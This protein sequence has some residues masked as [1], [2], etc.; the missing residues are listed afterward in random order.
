MGWLLLLL[1]WG[2][3]MQPPRKDL[4]E[5]MPDAAVAGWRN[6]RGK[7]ERSSRI[8]IRLRPRWGKGRN[9]TVLA[10]WGS[11]LSSRLQPPRCS[12]EMPAG[13]WVLTTEGSIWMHTFIFGPARLALILKIWLAVAGED[14]GGV[15]NFNFP[16]QMASL[17]KVLSL[18]HY[19]ILKM[20]N[21]PFRALMRKIDGL[22]SSQET[23]GLKIKSREHHRVHY[24]LRYCPFLD[25]GVSIFHKRMG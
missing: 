22:L 1:I 4:P 19:H 7:W 16:H 6:G 9:N 24:V 15:E 18:Q 8:Q 14:W 10:N 3:V 23:G 13:T 2:S 25:L 12:V 20:K 5:S 21:Q 11:L 17:Q